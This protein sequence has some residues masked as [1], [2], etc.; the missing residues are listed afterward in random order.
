MAFW[1]R[2]IHTGLVGDSEAEGAVREGRAASRGEEEDKAVARRYHDTLLFGNMR[3]AVRWATYREGGGCLLP[4]DQ[5]NKTRQLLDDVL[6]DKHPDMRVPLVENPM[7]VA[8]G[9]Y[10]E[11]PEM[12]PLNFTEDDVTWVA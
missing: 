8:F 7:Y 1:D 6:Q 9:K 10:I 3:Q 5:C 4:D 2:G 11:I 12:A